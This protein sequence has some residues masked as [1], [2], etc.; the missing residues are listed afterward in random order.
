MARD[1]LSAFKRKC[2]PLLYNF[3]QE[4]A[5]ELPNEM[6]TIITEHLVNPLKYLSTYFQESDIEW[7][8]YSS[9]LNLQI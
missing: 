5:L 8:H 6:R 4:N 2:F 7:V 9:E 3:L 1:T